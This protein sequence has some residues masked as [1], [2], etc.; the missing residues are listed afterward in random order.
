M[1]AVSCMTVQGALGL[2][3]S[4]AEPCVTTEQA[5]TMM[6]RIT[7]ELTRVGH[8]EGVATAFSSANNSLSLTDDEAK[9]ATERGAEEVKSG[10][11]Y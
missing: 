1:F 9:P 2:S 10:P 8:V 11:G 6:K 3:L 4:I 7:D 5:K